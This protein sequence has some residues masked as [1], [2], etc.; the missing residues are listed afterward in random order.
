MFETMNSEGRGRYP[1]GFLSFFPI[2]LMSLL[3]ISIP[4]NAQEYRS[5]WDIID[6]GTLEDLYSVESQGNEIWAFGENGIMIISLDGGLTWEVSESLTSSDLTISSSGYGSFLAA[7]SDGTILLKS[8]NDSEWS[9]ITFDFGDELIHGACLTDVSELVIVGGNGTIWTYKMQ[10]WTNRS[11]SGWDLLDVSF[12]DSERGIAVGEQGTILFSDDSGESWDYRDAPTEA[13]S[14]RITDVEFFSEIRAY[15]ITA[16]GGVIKSSREINT[17]VGFLWNMQYFESEGNSANLGENLTSIEIAT[18]NKFLLSGKQG[19]LSMSKDGGNIVT[20]QITPLNNSTSFNDI[21]M[22]DSFNG[23]AVGSNG[24]LLLTERSG[25]DEQIGFEVMDFSEFGNFVDYSKG[26]LIDGLYAT[27]NIVMFGIFLGFFLG[28]SLSMMKTSPTTLKEI[29]QRRSL[30]VVRMTGVIFTVIGVSLLRHLVP[31]IRNLGLDGWEYIYAPIG[32]I[33]PDGITGDLQFEN[34]VFLILGVSLLLLGVLFVSANGEYKKSH[35]NIIGRDIVWNPWGVRPL[36][37][38]ATIYT[39]IF[40]NTPLIVQFLFIHFG[41]QIGAFIGDPG[42]EM[43]EDSSN[44]MLSFLRDD[45]LSNR[46]CVSAI[47]ALGLNSG[48]YQCETIRGAISAIPSGQMEAGRSI[49]LNYMQT[50]RLVIMPQAI[51]ICIPPMGNEMVNLVLNSSLAMVIGYSELTRKAKLINAVTFQ[52]FWSYG[53]VLISY[54]IVTWTLALFLRYLEN[55]T[56]I[57]G[58]GISGGG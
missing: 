22:M 38:L 16:D 32:I 24:S 53:M 37:F 47:F 55:K 49:G 18:T 25:E 57:P 28:V 1:L 3:V 42:A 13:S 56:R 31:I 29:S 26:M 50:M 7:S 2:V 4:A 27:I 58:L 11:V 15:A 34:F 40:R 23:V 20:K 36:N 44:F 21:T 52:V 46:A 48:A 12:L 33:N 30:T 14:S 10:E 9:D 5:G 35:F 54:F 19:Y 41:V 43:L 17:A 51:R 39:D 6:S 45:I 8:T